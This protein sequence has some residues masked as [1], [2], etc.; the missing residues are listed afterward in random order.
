MFTGEKSEHLKTIIS[1]VI[2]VKFIH[3]NQLKRLQEDVSV[4]SF[5]NKYL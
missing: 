4:I 3:L 1:N 5:S 2:L